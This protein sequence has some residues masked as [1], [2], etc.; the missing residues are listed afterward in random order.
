MTSGGPE[1]GAKLSEAWAAQLRGTFLNREEALKW[2][3]R[4]MA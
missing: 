1:V 4:S 2:L 3:E